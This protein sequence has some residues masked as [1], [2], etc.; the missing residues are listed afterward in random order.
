[1]KTRN[2]ILKEVSEFFKYKDIEKLKNTDDCICLFNDYYHI[3]NLLFEGYSFDDGYVLFYSEI[4]FNELTYNI[5]VTYKDT[6]VIMYELDFDNK[7]LFDEYVNNVFDINLE[8]AITK[9]QK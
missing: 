8:Y 3:D 1:M 4:V 5:L 2:E 7:H 9:S 6:D